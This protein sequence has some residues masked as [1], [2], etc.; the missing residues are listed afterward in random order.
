MPIRFYVVVPSCLSY[1]TVIYNMLCKILK[2]LLS[3]CKYVNSAT[4]CE[5]CSKVFRGYSIYNSVTNL[6]ECV[7]IKDN[8][9]AKTP[10][11]MVL[12]CRD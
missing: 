5:K 2:R 1:K 10:G 9:L 3:K 8:V 11:D 6:S 4:I 12:H 7:K